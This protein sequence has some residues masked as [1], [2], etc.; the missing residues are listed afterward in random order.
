MSTL[1][2]YKS[3]DINSLQIYNTITKIDY[4][5]NNILIINNISIFIKISLIVNF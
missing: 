1:N 3:N 5:I 4:Y 2:K